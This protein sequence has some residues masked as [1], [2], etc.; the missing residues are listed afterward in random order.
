MKTGKMINALLAG[1]MAVSMAG[2]GSNDKASGGDAPAADA[3]NIIIAISPDYPPFD[4]LTTDGE[5]TGFDVEMGDWIFDWLN[6]NG[7]SFTHE[8]KQLSFDTIIS[9]IQ[10]NQVDL[11]LSGFTYDPERKVLFSDPYYGSAEVAM[12]TADSAIKTL[13]DLANKAIGAQAGTTGEQCA[14][15][16]EGAAVTAMQDMGILVET[17]KTGGIDALILDEPVAK[18]YAAS[19]AFTVLDGALIDEETHIIAAEGNT[20]LMDAVNKALK[21]FLESDECKALKEKYGL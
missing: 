1:L 12:V 19:G 2:C 15:E 11:G 16:I 8:W 14:N 3:Q 4:D 13:D 9:A 17:L 21:A 5:L 6:E 7:Y 18:N 10:A 20:E